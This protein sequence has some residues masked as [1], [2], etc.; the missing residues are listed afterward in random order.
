MSKA[1][2]P[3]QISISFEKLAE[4]SPVTI[5]G[6]DK[7]G[8]IVYANSRAEEV[9][10]LEKSEI[11]DRTYDDPDWK[12][13]DFEGNDYPSEGLPF[14]IVKRTEEPV[15]DVRPAIE[16]PDGERK[17]LSIN[18]S[19]LFDEDGVF[20]GMV[21]VME[22]ITEQVNMR[23]KLQQ[24]KER[25]QKYFDK[26][27]DAIFILKMGGEDHGKILE[28][29]SSAVDQ[30]G[31]SRE[32]LIG[33]N[34]LEDLSLEPPPDFDLEEADSKLSRG[35]TVQFTEK[36]E[37]K[38]GTEYWTEVVVTPLEY[39]GEQAN[40]SINRDITERKK[41]EQS[42]K[43]S[44]KKFRQIFN[45]ANDAIYLHGVTEEGLPGQFIEV[46][47]V[48]CQ[49]LGYSMDEFLEMSPRDI[50]GG[51]RSDDIPDI[52]EELLSEGHKT[53]EMVH[54]T[55]D[56]G[57]VPVEVSSHVFEMNDETRV[58]SLA[59]D[60]T[61]RKK[62]Q[63]RRELVSHSLD[64]AS[65]EVYWIKP[66]GSFVYTNEEVKQ[67]LGYT[68]EEFEDM[69][70][71]DVDPNPGHSKDKREQRWKRLKEEGVLSFESAHLTK[72]GE[73]YPVQINSHYLQYE[74]KEYE[75]AFA[76]DITERKESRRQLQQSESKLRQSFIELAETTSRVLGVRDPYT[77]R[78]EQQVGELAR[79][80]G[81]RMGLEEEKL[82]GLYLGG[83]LHDIGKIVVPETILTKPGELKDVE[84][85]MIRSH[86]EVGYN[87]IL[88][89]TDFPWPVAEMTLHHHERLDGSGY[90]DGLEG[91]ELTTEIRILG[92]VDVVEAMSTR[93]PYRTAKTKEETL[94]EIKSGKE[95]KYDPEVV[96][97]LIRMIEESE[98]EFGGK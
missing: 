56:G 86:P 91:D 3:N 26:T 57:S 96:D 31:Y 22:D 5:T 33:M 9:L 76:R 47:D 16:W 25:Y 48:A 12:I 45:N 77:Q 98:I 83:V 23:E 15:Y 34:M 2:N 70:V 95:N 74:G 67:K 18:A 69:H 44:E 35:K 10:G 84:W 92:A 41:A 79:E 32:E 52:M 62:L 58:L 53:F 49:M 75:F 21:S 29:N 68:A 14:Q 7:D 38:D 81:K 55:K 42:L 59:R 80:V 8:N 72:A 89:D 51:E 37:K 1:N 97:I 88:E 20:D 39:E 87:Q 24:S 4:T 82:L 78:H 60:I 13:T 6:L 11:T 54:E 40:L 66:D 71:W 28:V 85:Q 73:T 65:I 46:N 63:R 94:E 61:E 19:P 90:P 27:G 64:Q 50:D 17:F 93:R 43:E 30:T 36:K